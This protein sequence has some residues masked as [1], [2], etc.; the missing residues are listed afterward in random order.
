[1]PLNEKTKN[2][3]DFDKLKSMKNNAII[4]NTARGGIINE[5]DLDKALKTKSYFWSWA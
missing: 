1:M 2:L 5:I 4:I 3:I